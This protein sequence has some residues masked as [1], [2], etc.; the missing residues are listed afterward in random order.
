MPDWNP[1]Q[2]LK[3]EADRNK[4]IADL[5]SHVNLA[6]PARII[7]IGC[8]PGN[9]TGFLA[10]RWPGAELIGLDSSRA[11]LEQARA[12][13]PDVQWIEQ[14]AAQDLSALGK[15]DLVFSNAVLQWLP[16]HER[17]I[18]AWFA[19]LKPG[20]VLALQRP[21]NFDSPLHRTLLELAGSVSWRAKLSESRPQHYHPSAFYY[22][23][24]S[25]MDCAF[26][27]WTTK[28]YHVL[29]SHE[30]IIEWYKGTGFRPY[31]GQLS[32]RDQAA[33]LADMLSQIRQL[34]PPQADGKILFEFERLF[35]TAI[36]QGE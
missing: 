12:T 19:L 11:M 6:N 31:L 15:F 16:E 29:G 36:K 23:I 34:Y 13:L 35:F 22:D 7:D 27:L 18:L 25:G 9:S 30:D 8:G 1:A 3:F 14:D 33:F 17:V 2:Y 28:Y 26:E 10:R 20:G 24:L 4:P 21:H 5:L 32:G